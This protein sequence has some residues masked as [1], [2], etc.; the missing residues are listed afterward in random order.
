[1]TP[2][3]ASPPR[4]SR[5]S[6]VGSWNLVERVADGRQLIEKSLIAE[7]VVDGCQLIEHLLRLTRLVPFVSGRENFPGG[8]IDDDGL[9]RSR[10]HINADDN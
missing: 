6:H 4:A 1:M 2:V 5:R 3:A 10:S 9:D 8:W 7:S